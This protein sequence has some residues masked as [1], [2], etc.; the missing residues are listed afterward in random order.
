VSFEEGKSLARE[1][2]LLFLETSAKTALN[3]E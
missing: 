2:G 3:I 1:K